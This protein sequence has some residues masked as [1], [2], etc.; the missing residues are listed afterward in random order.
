[1]ELLYLA[2]DPDAWGKGLARR[3]LDHLRNPVKAQTPMELWVIA[4]NKRAI[5]SYERGGWIPKPEI[6]VR[7][8]AGRPERRDILSP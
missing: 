8:S 4:D 6:K 1:M 2:V 7:N 5:A 3:L